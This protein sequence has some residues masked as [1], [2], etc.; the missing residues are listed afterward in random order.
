MNGQYDFSLVALSVLVAVVASYTALGLA[1]RITRSSGRDGML[2]LAGGSSAM[3]IGIWSMHFIG[4]LAFRLPIQVVYDFWI[5]AGSLLAAVLVSAVALRVAA[6]PGGMAPMRMV[7]SAALMA[8]GISLMHYSGMAAIAI[9]PGIR[10][11]PALFAASVAVAFVASLAALWIMAALVRGRADSRMPVRIAAALVMGAAISG[12]HFT[13]MAAAHFAPDSV[14]IVEAGSVDQF[15]LA[16]TIAIGTL[17][18]LGSMVQSHLDSRTALLDASLRAANQE[19]IHLATHDALTGLP[20]RTL[21]G[22]R[23]ERV[24]ADADRSGGCFAILFIDLDRFKVVNDSAGHHVGD[25]LLRAMAHRIHGC[26]RRNDTLARLGGDEFVVLLKDLDRPESAAD[27]ARKIL[28]ALKPAFRIEPHELH[29]SA[30]VGISVYPGDGTTVEA[31]LTNADAAMYHA[32]QS[33]RNGYKF[34][35]PA[36]N[37]FAHERLELE[38]GL[39]HALQEGQF[40]LHYQPKVDI[41]S[42]EVVS[43]EALVRWRHPTRG[44]VGPNAFIPI[45]EESGLIG[46]LG[47]WVLRTACAQNRAWQDAGLKPMRV[48]VNVSAKQFRHGK[49]LELVRGVLDETR[50]EARYLEIELTE[51]TVMSNAEE[52][53]G[54][55]ES[56]SAM[57]VH[58]AI[59]DFGTGYSSLAYLKRLPLDV[60]KVDRSFVTD[61]A[62]SQDDVSIVQAVISMAHSLRLKVIAEG[63][64]SGE[65]LDRLKALGCD[66][67]QGFYYST[68]VDA[69]A[70]AAFMPLVSDPPEARSDQTKTGQAKADRTQA[71]QAMAEQAQVEQAQAEQAQAEQAQAER[72]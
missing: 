25:T 1:E 54:I 58:I 2:W 12:M 39:R 60:L 26:L 6:V 48:A 42:N 49:L 27:M 45:A 62:R 13:G 19:L 68:P 5:T 59:D 4:M 18:L 34:F 72:A 35:A 31:L 67:F 9:A 24:L 7:A 11:D 21:L 28:A 69:E 70:A 50:L 15:W 57:G 66:Q 23:I 61:L 38:S 17:A 64:E 14:C 33:G 65:Q 43:L 40:E 30:T 29:M 37:A 52:S 44:M 8:T 20:N 46:P 47:E 3:G 63:V 51:S 55:L 41:D 22:D 10:F 32:K 56:L 53:V 16:I 36:M 71:E